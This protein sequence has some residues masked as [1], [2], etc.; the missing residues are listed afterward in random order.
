VLGTDGNFYGTTSFGGP[1]NSGT[2]FKIKPGGALTTLHTFSGADGAN[3]WTGLIQA[4][5]GNFYGTTSAG[6]ANGGGTVFKITYGGT[7]TTLHGFAG[8]DGSQPGAELVQATD[9]NF[10][11]TTS[12]GGANAK[13]TVFKIT[14][15]GTLTTLYSFCA[16]VGC[17]DGSS[18]AAR[19]A[20]GSDGNF[21]GTTGLGANNDSGT[22]FKITPGGILTTLY[23]FCNVFS[24]TDGA[25]PQAGLMQGSD[26]NFYGTTVS[27]GNTGHQGTVFKITPGGTL[28][29]LHDGYGPTGYWP[30][31]VLIQASDGNFYGSMASG[32][33]HGAG[34]IFRLSVGLGLIGELLP[35]SASTQ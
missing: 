8:A 27:G 14:S 16:Q 23:S 35:S 34:V 13:G 3:P 10:Y 11:G 20:Q 22:V 5:D 2:V 33:S 7:L 31:V 32:G 1:N 6:G 25:N 9:G 18:P 12:S 28:T 17:S 26:G 4:T 19:L 21:Y 15:G 29:T 30:R 24:C